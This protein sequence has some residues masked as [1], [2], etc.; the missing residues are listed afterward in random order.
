MGIQENMAVI[1]AVMG[2]SAE[3]RCEK[4]CEKWVL[5]LLKEAMRLRLG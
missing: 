5:L 3:T 4:C 1:D 2:M